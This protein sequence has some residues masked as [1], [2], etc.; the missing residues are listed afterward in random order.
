VAVERLL[1]RQEE[2]DALLR[3]SRADAPDAD[4]D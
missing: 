2:V 3:D 1:E 4:A